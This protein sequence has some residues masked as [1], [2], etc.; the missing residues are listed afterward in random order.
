M[1]YIYIDNE[2][3]IEAVT[4]APLP[5]RDGFTEVEVEDT[6]L[7]LERH[8]YLVY[9]NGEFLK[10]ETPLAEVEALI[11]QKKQA[12]NYSVD[13]KREYPPIGDQLDALFHAGVFP[14]EMA[15]KIQAVKDAHP[16][17]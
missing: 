17:P 13:R 5:T 11:E 6:V 14:Q 2:N 12:I 1:K 3:N 10:K 16:K 8:Q 4:S 7:E 15:D 9:E